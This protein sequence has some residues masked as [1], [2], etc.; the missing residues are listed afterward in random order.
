MYLIIKPYQENG[1]KSNHFITL[2]KYVRHLHFVYK[3]NQFIKRMYLLNYTQTR[4]YH[5]LVS[6]V[7]HM[8]NV[9]FPLTGYTITKCVHWIY[10]GGRGWEEFLA[11]NTLYSGQN[12]EK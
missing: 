12:K 8:K 9:T 5:A 2:K 10:S 7:K 11:S 4:K 1:Y 6:M 3:T